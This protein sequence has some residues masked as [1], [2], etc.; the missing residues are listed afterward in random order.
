MEERKYLYKYDDPYLVLAYSLLGTYRLPVI[1]RILKD[2]KFVFSLIKKEVR[3]Q[4]FV[5]SFTDCVVEELLTN[6]RRMEYM[7]KLDELARYFYENL[8]LP[9]LRLELTRVLELC[10]LPVE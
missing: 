8:D 3:G 5:G 1:H 4:D 2:D 9:R 6:R 10:G 7:Y